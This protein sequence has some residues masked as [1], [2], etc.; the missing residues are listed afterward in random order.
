MFNGNTKIFDKYFNIL[1][2]EKDFAA[3]FS[4]IH[5]HVKAKVFG[6]I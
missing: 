1:M 6:E 4:K 5:E 2:N 3:K